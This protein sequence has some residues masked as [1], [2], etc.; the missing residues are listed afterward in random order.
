LEIGNFRRRRSIFLSLIHN[1][2]H[3]RRTSDRVPRERRTIPAS[4]APEPGASH[5]QWIPP[6]QSREARKTLSAE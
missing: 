2:R 4:E 5:D 6:L 3:V 1:L